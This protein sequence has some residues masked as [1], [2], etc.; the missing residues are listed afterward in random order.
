[1]S[2]SAI[3]SRISDRYHLSRVEEEALLQQAQSIQPSLN[4]IGINPTSQDEAIKTPEGISSSKSSI[5]RATRNY[6]LLQPDAAPSIPSPDKSSLSQVSS[7]ATSPLFT[8]TVTKIDDVDLTIKEPSI[9]EKTDDISFEELYQQVMLAIIHQ[10]RGA[11]LN[12]KELMKAEREWQNKMHEELM[13]ASESLASVQ[14]ASSTVS[15]ITKVVGPLAMVASG[16]VAIFTG[17]LSLAA[18]G[19]AVLGGLVAVD[20]L[21]DDYAKKAVAGWLARNVSETQEAWLSRIHIFTSV[22]SLVTGLGFD[23]GAAMRIAT[24]VAQVAADGVRTGVE[25]REKTVRALHKEIQHHLELSGENSGKFIKTFNDLSKLI[26]DLYKS[27]QE[28]H[29]ST[30]DTQIAIAR[31]A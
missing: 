30:K 29:K 25:W 20:A 21:L 9:T 8:R 12:Q 14:K 3:T 10:T 27:I 4:P 6:N 11:I 31:R 28:V 1:M 18:I 7:L 17:G 15:N 5:S 22:A 13:K 16:A 26:L 23:P 24:N 2:I 19:V